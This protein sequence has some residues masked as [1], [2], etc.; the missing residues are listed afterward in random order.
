MKLPLLSVLLPLMSGCDATMFRTGFEPVEPAIMYEAATLTDAEAPS[1][2]LSVVTYNIKFGGARIT[3]FWECGERYNMTSEEVNVNMAGLAEI[4]REID[5]DILMLQEVDIEATRSA[6]VDQVQY[7]L[8][9]TDLNYGAYA[10]QWK[11]DYIPSDGLGRTESGIATLARWPLVE[12]ERVAL[13][14]QVE[15]PALDRY[16]YLKR[17]IL[18]AQ[19]EVPGMD[20]FWSINTHLEA[21]SEDG[22]KQTQIGILEEELMALDAA[23]ATFVAGGDFNSLPRDSE[24]LSD[25]AD[26]CDGLFK[27]DSYVGEED[28]LDTLFSEYSSAMPADE[29]SADNAPWFSFSGDGVEWTRTL[30]YLFTNASWVDG[31]GVVHQDVDQGG[32]ETIQWS[33]HAPVSALFELEVAQ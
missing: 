27:G 29:Y 15:Q 12:A 31:S 18:R 3:F 24:Q 20:D 19:V 16:F 4:V 13:P 6:Y 25:F 9:N 10:S 32:I 14:L 33:D 11:S 23:G 30:D 26:E 2:A 8:D 7:L 22:T 1:E 5:P 28:F 21:F 17:A